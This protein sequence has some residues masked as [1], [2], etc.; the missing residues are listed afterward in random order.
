MDGQYDPTW[1]KRSQ[2]AIKVGY[3]LGLEKAL[4]LTQAAENRYPMTGK[5]DK[6]A[7]YK[8]GW[9]DASYTLTCQIQIQL[10]RRNNE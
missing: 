6:E 1:L 3:K 10:K 2:K 5:L 7:A 4:E 9:Y 8:N